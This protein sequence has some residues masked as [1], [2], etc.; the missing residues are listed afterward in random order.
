MEH[1][2]EEVMTNILIPNEYIAQ[3]ITIDIEE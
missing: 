2:F 3:D 1:M